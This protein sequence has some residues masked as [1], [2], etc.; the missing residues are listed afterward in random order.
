MTQTEKIAR[1]K[2][3]LRILLASRG[4]Y[5][6]PTASPEI[7]EEISAQFDILFDDAKKVCEAMKL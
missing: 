2:E 3:A 1:L 4:C 6:E 5:H 7:P